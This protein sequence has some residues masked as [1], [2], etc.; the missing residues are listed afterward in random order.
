MSNYHNNINK[1]NVYNLT[2]QTYSKRADSLPTTNLANN[3]ILTDECDADITDWVRSSAPD[4]WEVS[5]AGDNFGGIDE[6]QFLA[7]LQ[8]QGGNMV[9]ITSNKTDSYSCVGPKRC[10][11]SFTNQ[12]LDTNVKLDLL[13]RLFKTSP[14]KRISNLFTLGINHLSIEKAGYV[15]YYDRRLAKKVR[16]KLRPHH[17]HNIKSYTFSIKA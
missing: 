3:I 4:G 2:S 7:E 1:N 6:R 11:I 12:S 17:P 15:N 13:E 14:F 16:K 5:C 9:F 8:P 10:V